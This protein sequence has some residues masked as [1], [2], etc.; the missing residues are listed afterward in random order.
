[1]ISNHIRKSTLFILVFLFTSLVSAQQVNTMYFMEN[2]PL[3][4][5]LNPAFQPLSNVYV[6]VSPL[7]YTQ[8]SFGNNSLVLKDLIYKNPNG[9][10]PIWFLNANGDKTKFY[11][12]LQP[13]TS[14]QTNL[15]LNLLNFGFRTG[16]SYWSFG[17]TQ[18]LD[19]S[20]SVP[21]DMMKLLLYG[22]PNINENIFNFKELGPN[23]SLYTEA[24]LGYAHKINDQWSYGAK[25]KFLYGNANTSMS[26]SALGMTAS[27]DKW[28]INGSGAMNY[29]GPIAMQGDT[30]TNLSATAPNSIMSY[31]KP[32]GL[33]AGVD[34]GVTF[35]SIKNL[36]LSAAV[37]DLGM[38][39]WNS[40]VRN[41]NYSV[42]YTLNGLQNIGIN[43][44]L[45]DMSQILKDSILTPMLAS[46][47]T[48]I[49]SKAYTTYTSPKL[50][51]GAEYAFIKNALSIGLLSRTI[52]HNSRF[53]E[54]LTASVNGRPANW[55]NMSLSYSILNG[56][57][58]NLG[59]GIGLRTGFLHWFVAADFISF[60][61]ASYPLDSLVN[62]SNLPTFIQH[63]TIPVAYN[64]NNMNFSVGVS[65]VFGNKK[66]ADKDGVTDRKDVCPETPLKV[67]VDKKGC[68]ID[69]DGDGVPDYLDKC[70]GTPKE[71]YGLVDAKGC[72]L[73]TDGDK[74]P[75]YLDHCK[76]TP[77]AS[78]NLVDSVGCSLDTDKD[79]VADYLDKCPKTLANSKVDSVGC[80]LDSD[81]DGVPD[82]LDKCP[83]TPKEAR[84]TVD[85][86][87]CPIDTDLDAV[88]DYLDKCP[89][90]PEAER[91]LV[92]KNGC[93]KSIDMDTDG[94][95]VMDSVDNCP[96]VPG[97]AS[98]KGCPELKGEVKKLF[99]KALQGIQ[100]E[101]GQAVI[102]PFSYR[103]LN[104]IAGVLIANP[105]YLVEVG[106][107]S[108][109]VGKPAL[110]LKLSEKRAAAV[111]A[112]LIKKGV[113]SS[114]ITSKGYGD[115]KPQYDNKTAVGRA[116]N[117]RVEFVVSY[118]EVSFK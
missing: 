8:F 19:A 78:K 85:K 7:A 107:H 84:G 15:Q 9:G 74:V 69:T 37:I 33:G 79:G 101:T 109:N 57:F 108:D 113:D 67:K 98:N 97:P 32:Y 82:Y 106:G 103:I 28:T 70:P 114:R 34:L 90:T 62:T 89:N 54:E 99:Q 55:F 80:P 31:V 18:K 88:P 100:F 47:K 53:V 12:A 38:I 92:D 102:K 96:K 52:Y 63:K 61:N 49:T 43:S 13:T 50:N 46:S 117:R 118:E 72:P 73:D 2:M 86:N 76:N 23:V 116:N 93:T 60:N 58:S 110:N 40:N 64:R 115:T 51:V 68:P 4:N 75:D 10:L 41:V 26:N 6:G 3:R 48:S 17:V 94:D 59:A 87:G 11:N 5:N 20:V 30:I 22:T 104:Q 44:N 111:K 77:I 35:K 39:R 65:F 36:T 112:F 81:G 16:K 45:G 95:G 21:K 56:R 24:A 91:K 105:N 29:A 14:F 27:V 66:D 1:M 25:F 83:G 71:A 42:D